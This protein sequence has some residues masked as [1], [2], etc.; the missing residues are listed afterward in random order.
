L[1]VYNSVSSSADLV[2]WASVLSVL[3]L[4]QPDHQEV[5][6]LLADVIATPTALDVRETV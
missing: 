3:V 2:V 4:D 6:A 5:T 1:P